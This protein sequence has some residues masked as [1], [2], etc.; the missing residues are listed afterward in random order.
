[1][2]DHNIDI[3]LRAR[4]Q[5]SKTIRGVNKELSRTSKIGG[6]AG[7][8]LRTAGRNL[9]VAGVGVT[10]G[11]AVAVKAGISDLAEL[12]SAITSVD[13]AIKTVGLTG[14]V[15]G[16]QIAGWANEI[17]RDIQAAFDDKEIT[18][19]TTNLLRYGRVAEENIRPAMVVMTD[20]AARTGDVEG[21]SKQ[22]A[23]ALADPTKASGAL[24]KAGFIL[25]KEQQK[26]IDTMVK[27]GDVAGAQAAV[28]EAL[29]G[30]TKGAAAAMNGP[31]ADAM[32]T[33]ND[34]TEDSRKALAEGFLPV[35]QKVSDMLS[36]ELAKPETMNNIREFGKTLASGLDDLIEIAKALPWGTI[37][38]SLKIA[39]GGAKAVLGAF[40]GMPPWV[41]TA[42][43][44]GW[45]LNKL[46]GGA[47]GGIVGEMGKGLIKG[48]LGMN[49]GVVNIKAGVVNGAGGIGGAA[50]GGGKMGAAG[51]ALGGLAIIGEIAAV[52]AVQQ[53]VSAENS[54]IA[55]DIHTSLNSGLAI[56]TPA[57]LQA[58]LDGVN[59]GINDIQANPLNVLVAGSALD[60]LRAMR[61]S[62]ETELSS[63]GQQTDFSGGRGGPGGGRGAAAEV[64]KGTKP[65]KDAVTTAQGVLDTSILAN[66]TAIHQ[67]KDAVTG[68][69]NTQGAALK[70]A[71]NIGTSGTT[72]AV[73]SSTGRIVGAISSIPAPVLN[74]TTIVNVTGAT[75]TSSQTTQSR[76]GSSGGSRSNDN[77]DDHR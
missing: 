7:Q 8:G 23:K 33:L 60:E 16:A 35:I 40:A 26:Q 57:E 15:T 67:S 37:G 29:S 22:L 53:A 75:V 11:I 51:K 1:M 20:L 13:G 77:Y 76:T 38:D 21:A 68:A 14:K 6:M 45:G 72:V 34:V 25:T 46:T 30:S 18:S 27:A 12:E 17:E 42:V 10:A 69:T 39:G 44:T 41:Q 2:A 50:G 36:S 71:V 70:G 73:N 66:R 63:T 74:A 65:T 64:S 9:A 43:L 58:A 19:A 4:D 61:A 5:A 52:V 32:N 48:V 31:Y 24:R 56:K 62:L 59:Q 47:L 54:A 49:A 28:L 3:L 55:A